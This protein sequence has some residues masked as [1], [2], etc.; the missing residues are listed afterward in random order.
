MDRIQ[1]LLQEIYEKRK[2]QYG[3]EYS[4]LEFISSEVFNLVTYDSELD[5]LFATKIIEVLKVIISGKNFEYIENKQDYINYI[6]VCQLLD[7][8]NWI[9]WGTSIRG[10]WI[11][12]F[13]EDN[14]Q[15]NLASYWCEY[16]NDKEW[17]ETD[18][19][20]PYS[21][22]NVVELIKWIEY[23]DTN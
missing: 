5:E 8:M 23:K 17:I 21:K 18:L 6:L 19:R 22:E 13:D 12:D 15:N 4:K 10:A 3:N 2:E 20:I 16:Y 7:K 1:D 9:D 14:P 11:E